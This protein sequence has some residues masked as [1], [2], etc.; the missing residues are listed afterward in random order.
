MLK[1]LIVYGNC[2]AEA[3]STI[4][5]KDPVTE[6]CFRVLY[7]RSFDHPSDGRD[8][9]RPEDVRDC[10]VLWEQ[11]DPRPFPHRDA[12]PADCLTVKFPALDFNL[13]WPFNCPNPCDEPEPP[14]FP[15]GRFPYGDRI[16]IESIGKGMA[17]KKILNYY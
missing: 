13:L 15:F 5:R 17:P 4:F 7:L 10:G 16:I 6:E 2:Q 14:V 9:L 8:E 11:H 1:T 3:I 12:L